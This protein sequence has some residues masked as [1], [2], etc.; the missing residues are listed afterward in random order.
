MAEQNNRAR[1]KATIK[2]MLCTLLVLAVG[3]IIYLGIGLI[4]KYKLEG[5]ICSSVM[6]VIIVCW[7]FDSFYNHFKND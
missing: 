1:L 3:A 7:I 2:A 4:T 6:S 5:I